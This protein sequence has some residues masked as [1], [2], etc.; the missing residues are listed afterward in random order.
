MKI[1]ALAL[2]D[3]TRRLHEGYPPKGAWLF[4]TPNT[5]ISRLAHF[6]GPADNDR[7]D[8]QDLRLATFGAILPADYRPDM[9]LVH[10]DFG[11]E[12][13]ARDI[14]TT[15][16]ERRLRYLLFGPQVTAWQNTP[17][18]NGCTDP[19]A[20]AAGR[21]LS[22][23]P[24]VIGDIIDAWPEIKHDADRDRLKTCYRASG[25]PCYW[26]PR[27]PFGHSPEMNRSAQQTRFIVG[28]HCPEPVAPWCRDRLY[29]GSERLL[30]RPDEIVGEILLMPGDRISLLDDDIAAEPEYYEDIFGHIGHFRRNWCVRAGPGLFQHP[31]LI[32]L[33]VKSGVRLVFMNEAFLDHKIEA[34]AENK[35]LLSELESQVNLLHSARLL[36]GARVLLRIDPEH[37][38]DF[39]ILNNVLGRL[40]LDLVEPFFLVPDGRGGWQPGCFAYRPMITDREPGWLAGRFYA[41]ASILNRVAVSSRHTGF[42]TTTRYLIPYSLAYRQNF[43]EGLDSERVPGF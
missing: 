9:V 36:V 16:S 32:S 21:T 28:C 4:M 22:A 23:A 42:Y 30:R 20:E 27:R 29:Y 12:R 7:L 38:T 1:L 24:R 18:G 6:I 11:Q 43:L 17:P 33:M 25:R 2:A 8:Y 3:E 39:D 40:N 35:S 34:A 15:L 5:E 14:V 31:D 26:P 41:M 37:P 13:V 19:L 10:V